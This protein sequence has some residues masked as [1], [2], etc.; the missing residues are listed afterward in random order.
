M[1]QLLDELSGAITSK[2]DDSATPAWMVNRNEK[3]SPRAGRFSPEEIKKRYGIIEHDL[4]G[5]LSLRPANFDESGNIEAPEV[6]KVA[7]KFKLQEEHVRNMYRFTAL[8]QTET[9]AT[10]G[11]SSSVGIPVA[12]RPFAADKDLFITQPEERKTDQAPT[13]SEYKHGPT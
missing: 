6:S 9:I 5:I 7:A 2:P 13:G 8:V 1:S 11:G 4:K 3:V 12:K 10:S